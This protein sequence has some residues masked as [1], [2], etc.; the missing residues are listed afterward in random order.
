MENPPTDL[1]D[2]ITLLKQ[3]Q[4]LL[5]SEGKKGQFLR[6]LL[7]DVQQDLKKVKEDE[8]NKQPFAFFKPSFEQALV[9]NAWMYGI[10]YTCVY[11]ANRIGKTT[12]EVLNKFLW[13]FPNDPSWEKAG[14]FHRYEDH[15]G[16]EVQVFQRPD[17]QSVLLIHKTILDL[18]LSPDPSLPHYH[19]KNKKV[20]QRLQEE[21]PQAY[22]R[23]YPYAPWNKGG[24]L[25][26]GAPDHQHHK[27]K[28]MP[29]LRKYLPA[30]SIIR[31]APSE[32]QMTIE[33]RGPKRTT[34]WEI[35][36]LSYESTETKWASD[37]VEMILLTEGVPP[38]I[39]KEVKLRFTSPGIGSHDFTPYEAAN[40]GAATALAHRIFKGTEGMPLPY[41]VF[42]KFSVYNAPSHILPSEKQAGL[43]KA[44]KDDPQGK[45]R[46]DGEF[47]TSS[48]LIL[49]NLSRDHHILP[50]TVEEM[51]KRI[52]DGR[53][54]RGLD[55]GYDHPTSCTWA[56]LT[57]TNQWIIY[58]IM[59]EQGLDI[60]T[61]CRKI[62]ELSNNSLVK[63]K[64]GK[65]PNEFYFAESNDQPNSEVVCMTLTDYH[66]FKEDETTGQPYANNYIVSGL[67]IHESIHMGPKDRAV[68]FNGLL[69]LNPFTPSL[70][71]APRPCKPPGS[72]VY[73]LQHGPGVLQ[74]LQLWEELY[75]ERI[76]RGDNAG[77]PKD[78]V[79]SHGDDELDS[80]SYVVCSNYV[81]TNHRPSAR[82]IQHSEPERAT[83]FK[84]QTLNKKFD[85]AGFFGSRDEFEEDE[86][87]MKLIQ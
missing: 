21:I 74:S 71:D 39:F 79:P 14:I 38:E 13:M 60:P 64:W 29:I 75:W 33:I 72:K 23:A 41:H 87:T 28:M 53:I 6:S 36:G 43:I 35:T 5:K 61:R 25:W 15:E 8:I 16:R 62:V 63:V 34:V 52:P 1:K 76:R 31:D 58:R 7:K 22:Q 12:A 77:A 4:S 67:Q 69:R 57:K 24:K 56:Y 27:E 11:T 20:L 78:E 80:T 54:Y 85:M 3:Y 59:S 19:P 37:A 2:K 44:F 82:V 17:I 81:W 86:E 66:T 51:F 10:Q 65:G 30:S 45:A 83:V 73:F 49:S 46:L 32:R 26:I 40:V 18:K 70:H 50:W 55:P 48:A 68:T 9:L 84:S 42:V 47:Y